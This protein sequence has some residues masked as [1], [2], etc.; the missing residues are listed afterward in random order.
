MSPLNTRLLAGLSLLVL[1]G[2]TACEPPVEL[3]RR[4]QTDVFEQEIRKT[5]DILLVVDNSC[6]MVDEQIKLAA[7]FDSFIEQFLTAE[8]NY[9][10]GVVTT[11]VTAE[12]RGLLVGETPVITSEIPVDEA[13]ALF[14]ENVK[15]CATGSGFERGL[16]AARLALDPIENLNP[17]FLREDAALSIVFISDE[18]DDSALPVG[19][20]LNFFKGLKGDRGYRDDTLIN[21]SAVVGPPPEGCEQPQPVIPDCADGEAD[22][23][24]GNVD[25]DAPICQSSYYCTIADQIETDCSDGVDNEGD[26]A[27]DCA[28]ADCAFINACH[29]VGC[30]NGEDDD[31]DGA[32]DCEDI[33]CLVG[34]PGVCGE[35]SCDDG[36]L[37]HVGNQFPNFDLDCDD[38]SCFAYDEACTEQREEIDFVERCD[39]AVVL[40]RSTGSLLETDG[41]DIDSLDGQSEL[42]GCD[43]PDCASYYLCSAEL[44]IEG[45]DQC[46]DCVDNDADGLEDCEDTDC[47]DSPFCDNPYPIESGDRYIDVALRSGGIITS[48]CAEEFSGLVR[49][50]GLNISGLRSIFYL[51][52]WPDR[53]TL[54]V[55]LNE[56]ADANLIEDG[57]DYDPVENRVLF[58]EGAIP[59]EDSTI[60]ITYTR[61][62]IPPTEQEGASGASD[63]DDATD[64]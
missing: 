53:T 44:R 20:Y 35:I 54:K 33:D 38:P 63:D 25:C 58:A 18:D 19:E 22:D 56:V 23:A 43:D 15:V 9:Q 13:R 21:L 49:E 16:E 27:V 29:E 17:E 47:L 12:E 32:I 31:G 37:S 55:Y 28:D 24:D 30:F 60:I 61:S 11:D 59:A 36:E 14:Q 62:Q 3:I 5:V 41:P 57:Y 10:I 51:T 50:L 52:A 46:N 6:S 48:I 2:T 7:N 8:V 4:T 26:G 45:H 64:E 40:D 1:V 42:A 34:F 39:T